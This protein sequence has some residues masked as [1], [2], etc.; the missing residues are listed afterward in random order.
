[1][2][3]INVPA[4]NE[5]VQRDEKF[6]DL[7]FAETVRRA[8]RQTPQQRLDMLRAALRDAEKRGLIPK[9]DRAAHE[10]KLLWLIQRESSSS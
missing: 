6:G 10:R 7:V 3:S 9:R 5:G 8:L 4:M 1:V 2:F